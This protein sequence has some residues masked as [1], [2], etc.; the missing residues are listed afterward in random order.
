MNSLEINLKP[1]KIFKREELIGVAGIYCIK[2]RINN[3]LYIGQSNNIGLR[4]LYHYYNSDDGLYFHNALKKYG[5]DNF[6]IYLL[7]SFEFLNKKE[8]D[9]SEMYFITKFKSNDPDLGYNLTKGG[10]GNFGACLSEETKI[11]IS[12]SHNVPYIAYNF[13]TKEYIEGNSKKEIT[14]KIKNLGYTEISQAKVKDAANGSAKY[15]LDFLIA[16]DL[17][18]LNDKISKFKIPIRK[19]IYLYNY[20]TKSKI[21][22]FKNYIEAEKYIRSEG[23][24]LSSEH[25]CTA[26]KKN[27]E[28]IKDFLIATSETELI[29]K[30][31]EFSPYIYFYNIEHRYILAFETM[32]QAQRTIE[33]MGIKINLT[34]I[35]KCKSGTQKQ[36]AG[37]IVGKNKEELLRRICAYT[38][39]EINSVAKLIKEFNLENS[40]DTLNW[41]DDLNKIS[42]D[43]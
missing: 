18:T 43:F 38:N 27:S 9:K 15:T 13:I 17:E 6:D 2:N 11:K 33:Q 16:H 40:Q 14:E 26:I 39:E 42:V 1:Y 36:T 30:I 19:E 32:A 3:K 5:I 37:F 24:D 35:S 12:E 10:H 28:Y 23:F 34:G 25:V 7:E 29:R 8:Q 41:A 31:R 20:K 21:L 4:I 22:K